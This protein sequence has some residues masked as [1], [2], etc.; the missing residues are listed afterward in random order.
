[1]TEERISTLKDAL[2]PFADEGHDVDLEYRAATKDGVPDRC[3]QCYPELWPCKHET[4]RRALEG[5]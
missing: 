2:R 1:M 4:A 3:R 5:E